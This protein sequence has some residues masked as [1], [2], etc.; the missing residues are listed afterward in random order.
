MLAVGYDSQ[1]RYAYIRSIA[2]YDTPS[3]KARSRLGLTAFSIE[4]ADVNESNRTRQKRDR[5]IAFRADIA[6]AR[7]ADNAI[8]ADTLL[9]YARC[10]VVLEDTLR[11]HKHDHVTENTFV[12]FLDCLEREGAAFTT[13]VKY[14]AALLHFQ[15]AYGYGLAPGEPAWASR[16]TNPILKK[17]FAGYAYKAGEAPD[18]SISSTA[19]LD[20]NHWKQMRDWLLGMPPSPQRATDLVLLD[21]L[22]LVILMALRQ[23]EVRTALCR[24][25]DCA[26]HRLTIVQDKRHNAETAVSARRAPAGAQPIRPKWIVVEEA[27]AWLAERTSRAAP[28]DYIFDPAKFKTQHMAGLV[29]RAAAAL[30]WPEDLKWCFHSA[31]HGGDQE[32]ARILEAESV[33]ETPNDKTVSH[34][35]AAGIKAAQ[36]HLLDEALQQSASTRYRYLMSADARLTSRQQAIMA[37]K[38]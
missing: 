26:S 17:I 9:A 25:Y 34:A 15:T 22:R 14:Q 13:A 3:E 29:K 7:L 2:G 37:A 18:K 20:L 31:R 27:R 1:Q 4:L 5:D 38:T 28:D 8:Q 12:I 23:C 24:H 16:E 36:Q 33:T 30:D 32:I 21:G 10:I 35:I 6:R 11:E 19:V